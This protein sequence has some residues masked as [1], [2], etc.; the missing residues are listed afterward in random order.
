MHMSYPPFVLFGPTHIVMIVLTFLLPVMLVPMHRRWKFKGFEPIVRWFFILCILV[1]WGGWYVVAGL[2]GWLTWGDGLPM[3]LCNW[4][5]AAAMLALLRR[6]QGA[7]ELAYF[8]A[9]CGTLQAVFSPDL[10]YDFPEARTVLFAFFHCGIVAGVLY[11][12]LGLGMRP[13]PASLRRALVWTLGYAAVAGAVDAAMKTN[14]GFLRAKPEHQS[15]FA[16]MPDWPYY[17]IVLVVLAVFSMFVFYAPFF[18]IDLAR[19][20]KPTAGRNA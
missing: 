15:L 8:W 1:G 16:L 14:Y 3:N 13:H 5:A 9:M 2:Q 10:P 18:F 12:T 6:S 11:L 20:H 17:L 19:K 4:A 7:Y